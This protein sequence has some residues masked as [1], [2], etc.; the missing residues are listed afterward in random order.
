MA[1]IFNTPKTNVS[2]PASVTPIIRKPSTTTK[3]GGC[4][5]C[6]GRK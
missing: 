4:S 6:G 5:T 3:K 1:K 2:K